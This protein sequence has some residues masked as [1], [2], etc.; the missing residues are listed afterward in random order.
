MEMVSLVHKLILRKADQMNMYLVISS[1]QES[2]VPKTA[3]YLYHHDDRHT[4]EQRNHDALL[5]L[6]PNYLHL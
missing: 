4:T 5:Q 1:D 2:D 3:A 6:I